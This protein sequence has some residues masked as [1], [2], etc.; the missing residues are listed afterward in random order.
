MPPGTHGNEPSYELLRHFFTEPLRRVGEPALLSRV[1]VTE[2]RLIQVPPFGPARI[3]RVGGAEVIVTKVE[4]RWPM[5]EGGA[6]TAT[7]RPVHRGEHAGLGSVIEGM[8]FWA[9]PVL[10][11]AEHFHDGVLWIL[12]VRSPSRHHVVVRSSNSL[13]PELLPDEL[14]TACDY[15]LRLAG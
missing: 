10:E 6:S 7:R 14:A 11:H 5:Q 3:I 2:Y 12:E 8:N 13:S 1:A 15:M 9:T 4:A